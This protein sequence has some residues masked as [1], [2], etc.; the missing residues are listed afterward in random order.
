MAERLII[1]GGVAA[2]MSAAA[3][4][5][6]VNA[7]LEIVVYE[8][9]GYISYGA[10]G[11]P[12]FIKG[13]VPRLED[14]IARTP[15]QM[16]AQGVMAHVCHEV[17][18][19][20][21]VQQ[22][23]RVMDQQ[24]GRLLTDH[25]DKLIITTGASVNRPPIPGANL[26]GVFTL[27]T[28][29]DALAIRR[30]LVE[31]KPKHAVIVG[32]GYIGLEMAEALQAHNV[33]VTLVEM[34]DQ[35]MPGLDADL[36]ALVQTEL[37]AHGVQICLQQAVKSFLGPTLVREVVREVAAKV[38]GEA[39][40]NGRLRIHEVLTANNILAADM[41]VFGAGGRPNVALAQAAG[42]HLGQSGAIIVDEQQ[43]TNLP[44]VFAAGAAAESQHLILNKPV[45]WPLAAPANKQGRVAGTNAAGGQATSEAVVGTAVVKT[46]DLAIAVTGLTEKQ[47]QSAG[48]AAASVTIKASSR[49][50][51][52]PDSAP[53]HLK[54]VYETG[55]ERILG[56]QMV[57]KDGVAQR[58]DV[59]A[60][61]LRANWTL[62]DV[63]G[64]DLAY[65]P[66]FAPVWDPILLAANVARKN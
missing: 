7:D 42:I 2:G 20:D 53:I 36:A 52:M 54:L 41:V 9:S 59:M 8:K 60:A 49:A 24:N 11:F 46:F 34:A 14:L 29:E 44:N 56:A 16:A 25:W 48:L 19:I 63:A 57:G 13:D 37:Q 32:A 10:C 66:P 27:R 38:Q 12:Y 22:I 64:L 35:V 33:A 61:A 47:A 6:R 5:R 39:G 26:P 23:V 50:H 65:A 28:V 4:A 21:P 1:I 58:I 31:K 62:E 30:W 51:Y 18:E 40:E 15:E 55:T 43:R 45:Y 17:V 3:K